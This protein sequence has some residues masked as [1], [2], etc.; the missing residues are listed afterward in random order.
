MCVCACVCVCVCVWSC[1]TAGNTEH[2]DYD[3]DQ[4]THRFA[5]SY[6]VAASVAAI[7][8][9]IMTHGPVQA[10]MYLVDSFEVYE[11]RVRVHVRVHVRV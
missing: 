3:R 9:D 4:L 11:V 6:K 1:D 5:T 7:Q 8:T 2:H 10:S